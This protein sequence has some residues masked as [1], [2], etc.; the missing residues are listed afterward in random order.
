MKQW[1]LPN[2]SKVKLPDG[3]MIT[4]VK[5]DGVYAHWDVGGVLKIGSYKEFGFEKEGGYYKVI[6]Q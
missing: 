5:M 6:K 4:F 1:E 3:R 2:N